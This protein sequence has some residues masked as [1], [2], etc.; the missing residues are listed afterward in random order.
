MTRLKFTLVD[1]DA[2]RAAVI[3]AALSRQGCRVTVVQEL[4]ELGGSP[5]RSIALVADEDGAISDVVERL[6]QARIAAKVIAFG[7]R[8]SSHQIVKA[9]AAGAV[10][11]L[12]WPCDAHSILAAA[13]AATTP[14]D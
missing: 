10:D 11:Y 5:S 13:D 7:E 9:M 8:P 3:S 4:I 1:R 2:V 6:K 14:A 12:Q